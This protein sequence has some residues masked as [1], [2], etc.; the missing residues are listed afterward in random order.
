M[1]ELS[2][3]GVYIIEVPSALRAITA[4][5]TSTAAFIGMAEKGPDNK[6]HLVT[7]YTEFLDTFGG[8]NTKDGL[9]IEDTHTPPDNNMYLPYAVWAFFQNGGRK[10]YII[11]LAPGAKPSSIKVPASRWRCL[12]S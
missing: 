7:S 12:Y 2:Y 9:G 1:V 11:R 4:A 10:C 5:S 6:A 3:P 8:F